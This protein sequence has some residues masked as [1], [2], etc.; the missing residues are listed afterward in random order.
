MMI[1]LKVRR[2]EAGDLPYVLEL[3][4][5]L[6]RHHG[7]VPTATLESLTQDM[8]RSATILVACSGAKIIGY[9]ALLPLAQ[10][11]FAKRGL[12]IHHLFVQA[13]FRRMRVGQALIYAARDIAREE[14]CTYLIVGTHPDNTQAQAMYRTSGFLDAPVGGVRFGMKI[15]PRV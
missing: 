8:Q 7:D 12:D 15:E 9:A 5:A 3:V 10:I 2:A 4:H 13:A 1:D 6:A 11:Q 14:G